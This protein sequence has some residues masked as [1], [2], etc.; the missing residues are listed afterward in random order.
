MNKE[1]HKIQIQKIVIGVMAAII[2]I[3]AIVLLWWKG[4]FLPDWIKWQEKEFKY[5]EAQ[6]RLQNRKLQVLA[7]EENKNQQVVFRSEWDWCV[8]DVLAY[9]I[10][11]DGKDELVMLVWKHGSYGEHLPIW[12]KHNDIRLEQHIFIYQWEEARESKLRPVWMSSALKYQVDNISKGTGNRLVITD[13]AGES[14]AWQWQDFGLTL[15]GKAKEE[16]VSFLCAGDNLIHTRLL[17]GEA[18]D[19]DSFYEHIRPEI[20]KADLASVNQETI[21]VEDRGLI[22]DYPRFGTPVAVGDAIAAAGFDIVTLANNHVLDKGLY[23]IRVTSAFYDKQEGMTYLGINPPGQEKQRPEES[24]KIIEKNGIRIALLNYTYG[25]NG[26]PSPKEAPYVV[27]RFSDEERVKKQLIYAREDADAVIVFA[28]WGT[29]Y[30][31]EADEKQQYWSDMLLEYG[32]DVVI[33]THPH[34][35]QPFEM[36][37]GEDGHQMLVYYSLGNLVSGQTR[38]DCQIG[39]LARFTIVKSPQGGISIEDYGLDALK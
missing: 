19:Y 27:E 24:V 38:E 4:V 6:I 20:E 14:M 37:T 11:Q 36:R 39:G 32:A 22:S 26:L 13:R 31:S 2:F 17:Q 29:E 23:G 3:A 15:A 18:Q 33:G 25:T 1:K 12:V 34:V 8:Q 16:R 10:N 7:A 28:H 30:S 5:E 21:F 9:D 35:L